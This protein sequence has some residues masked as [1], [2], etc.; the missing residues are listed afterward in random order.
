VKIDCTQSR[1]A[2]WK[3]SV[4]GDS[5]ELSEKS[6]PEERLT[7]HCSCGMLY[8][9]IFADKIT[10]EVDQSLNPVFV[11][12]RFTLGLQVCLVWDEDKSCYA[13]YMDYG[14]HNN[15]TYALDKAIGECWRTYS[16]EIIAHIKEMK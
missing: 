14:Q 3:C 8:T 9:A 2:Q 7:Y 10:I 5:C 16:D 1:I 13:S 6:F 11:V 4:C 12:H 15:W